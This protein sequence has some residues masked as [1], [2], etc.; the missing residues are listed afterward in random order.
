MPPDV[1]AVEEDL[2]PVD[3]VFLLLLLLLLLGV[4]LLVF[5][6]LRLDQVEER[7]VQQLLLQVLL[8]VEQGHVEQIHRLVEAWIDLQ[9]LPELVCWESP[10]LM[11][12]CTPERARRRAV[13]VG[14]R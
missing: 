7:I 11:R 3:L 14:P 10:V 5:L 12:T 8:E 13:R 9:L 6:L 2:L 4:L 1:E